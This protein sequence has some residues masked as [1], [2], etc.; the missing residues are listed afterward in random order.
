MEKRMTYEE[1]TYR[2]GEPIT[3]E[4]GKSPIMPVFE[5]LQ[6]KWKMQTLYAMMCLTEARFGQIQS[7]CDGITPAALSSALEDLANVG[8]ATQDVSGPR[9]TAY[10]LKDQGEK[11]MPDFYELMNRGFYYKHKDKRKKK[12]KS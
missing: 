12:S 7:F 2:I 10:R 4:Y 3:D 6:G 8:F 1:F 9:A 11:I 5:L